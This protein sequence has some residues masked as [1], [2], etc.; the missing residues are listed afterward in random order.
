MI[1]ALLTCVSYLYATWLLHHKSPSQLGVVITTGLAFCLH[2][3]Q[4][5][6]QVNDVSITSVLTVVAFCMTLVGAFRYFVFND[7]IAYPVVALIAAVCVW[8]PFFITTPTTIAHSG[9]LKFHIVLSIAAY[10]AL[11]FAALY[12]CF[13]LVQDYRL[14]RSSGVFSLTIPL[15]DLDRTM[16]SFTRVGEML[17]T[18]SLVT[19]IF[20]IHDIWAQQV[21]HK[22]FFGLISWVIIG[23]VLSLHYFR[24]F[25]GRLAAL[26]VLGGFVCLM[27]AYFG[28]AFVLQVL[29]TS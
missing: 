24:G 16:M 1:I 13:L 3:F 22:L 19:G 8:M 21:A 7:R 17:L 4:M 27:L 5:A 23:I 29:L 11:S 9:A 25:R 26:W 14:R 15:N 10:I 12:A 6:Y 18:L 28:S 20:F 2:A